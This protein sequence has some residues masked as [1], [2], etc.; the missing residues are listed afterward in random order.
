M[1]LLRHLRAYAGDTLND[2]LYFYSA[3]GGLLRMDLKDGQMEYLNSPSIF[4]ESTDSLCFFLVRNCDK[5]YQNIGRSH[6]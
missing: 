4:S 5:I 1:R 6:V 2:V 3:Y